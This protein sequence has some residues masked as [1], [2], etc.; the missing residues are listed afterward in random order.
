MVTRLFRTPLRAAPLLALLL[1]LLLATA[2]AAPPPPQAPSGQTS[3]SRDGL[4]SPQQAANNFT[5]VVKRVEPVAEAECRARTQNTNCDFRVVVDDRPG[6]PPNAYQTVDR[7]GRPILAFTIPLIADVKNED[8]L[9]FIMGHEAA[10]HI[11]AHLTK[12]QDNAMAG[13]LVAGIL[14]SQLGGDATAIEAAQEFGA[15]VGARSYSKDFELE[16]DA[17]GTVIAHRAGYDPVKGAEYFT[18]IPDPGNRFLGTHPP[19]AARMQ[20]VR[21]TAARLN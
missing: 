7:S 3:A 4:P 16:A 13:A 1:A 15:T 9:A 12:Q 20:T 18:R 11:S 21:A 10:H 19:N 6:Q 5:S 17:L 8:E 14:A 2:C